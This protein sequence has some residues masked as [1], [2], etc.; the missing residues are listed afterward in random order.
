MS[1]TVSPTFSNQKISPVLCSECQKK[2][3]KEK[4]DN[5]SFFEL[6]MTVHHCNN[7]QKATSKKIKFA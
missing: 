4:A 6:V 2:I 7:C 3:T 5:L 1:S